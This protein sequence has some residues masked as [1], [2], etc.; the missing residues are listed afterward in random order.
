VWHDQALKAKAHNV[1]LKDTI[2]KLK[3]P[4]QME[5]YERSGYQ[6]GL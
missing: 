4:A 2:I 1:I 6:K 5:K 3:S